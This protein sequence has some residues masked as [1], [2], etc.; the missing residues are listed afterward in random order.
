MSLSS[1]VTY[2][3]RLTLLIVFTFGLVLL[4]VPETIKQS[5]EQIDETALQRR[6]RS[7]NERESAAAFE[8]LVP[9]ALTTPR[10]EDTI[11]K[12]SSDKIHHREKVH[13]VPSSPMPMG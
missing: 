8:G 6:R 12:T 7:G 13:I 4:C 10:N 11:G 9:L 2:A 1:A 5:L 3:I